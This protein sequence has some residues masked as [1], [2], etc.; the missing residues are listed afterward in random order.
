[1]A[2]DGWTLDELTQRV[3]QALARAAQIGAYPGP[4]DGRARE[5]PDSRAIRWYTDYWPGR[6]TA[7]HAGAHGSLRSPAPESTHRD[8]T[9]AGPRA[10]PR[11]D[12][13]GAD[14]GGRC[15]TRCLRRRVG[16]AAIASR[17]LLDR[18]SCRSGCG[19]CPGC[20]SGWGAWAGADP[21]SSGRRRFQ[22]RRCLR[23]PGGSRPTLTASGCSR[24]SLCPVGRH[25]FSRGAS[26]R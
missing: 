8:Q 17:A 3:G 22:F 10:Q 4:R 11:G 13:G 6:P 23:P 21:G 9:E 15:D 14:R 2:D 20:R 19:A 7:G 5:V 16:A 26:C 18:C 25:S 24:V 1:M 12:S